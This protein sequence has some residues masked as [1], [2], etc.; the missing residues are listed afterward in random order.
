MHVDLIV[1]CG[2]AVNHLLSYDDLYSTNVRPLEDIVA[3]ATQRRIKLLHFVSSSSYFK[4]RQTSEAGYGS[5][6]WACDQL[7]QPEV[8]SWNII[9]IGSW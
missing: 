2:A 9:I 4:A 1:H 8:I 7:L 5:T 3:M 6:K